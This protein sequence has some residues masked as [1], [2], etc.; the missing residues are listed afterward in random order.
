MITH[1]NT[2]KINKY[3]YPLSLFILVD[4]KSK[5]CLDIQVFLN[6]ETQKSYEWVSIITDIIEYHWI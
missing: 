3:N 5:L 6:D 2:S 1:D 4:N